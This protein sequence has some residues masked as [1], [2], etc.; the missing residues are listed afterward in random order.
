M[1]SEKENRNMSANKDND[2]REKR[3]ES[4]CNALR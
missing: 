3:T 1:I 4:T 2:C